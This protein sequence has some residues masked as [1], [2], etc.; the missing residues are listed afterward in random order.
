MIPS[1]FQHVVNSGIDIRIAITNP[2]D[3][4]LGRRI[5]FAHHLNPNTVLWNILLIY[6]HRINSNAVIGVGFTHV[7]DHSACILSDLK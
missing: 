2:S 5:N 6:A 7:V 4:L 3:G 1:L